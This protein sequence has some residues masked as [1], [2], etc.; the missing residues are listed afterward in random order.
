VSRGG[1]GW[2]LGG[3][4]YVLEE[5]VGHRPRVWVHVLVAAEELGRVAVD[6]QGAGVVGVGGLGGGFWGGIGG[7]MGGG[8]E[9]ALHLGTAGD[10][11]GGVGFW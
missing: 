11:Q 8:W 3:A 2:L 5:L 9:E 10:G 7:R 1:V 6:V 4:L